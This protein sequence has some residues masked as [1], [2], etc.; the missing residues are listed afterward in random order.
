MDCSSDCHL[1]RLWHFIHCIGLSQFRLAR[2]TFFVARNAPCRSFVDT[3]L[4]AENTIRASNSYKEIVGA[5]KN[6]SSAAEE[7]KKAAEDAYIDADPSSDT[8]MVNLALQSKNDSL[9][10]HNKAQTLNLEELAS[11]RAAYE[12]RLKGLK[13]FISAAQKKKTAVGGKLLLTAV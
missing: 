3:K 5:L 6:A 10:L 2:T 12:E 1:R 11:E 4:A 8:S 13:D 9:E 7:A